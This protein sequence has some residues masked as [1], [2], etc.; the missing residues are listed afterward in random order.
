MTSSRPP[1]MARKTCR[2]LTRDHHIINFFL[3]S[4]RY[5][6]SRHVNSLV[7]HVQSLIL[8]L[9]VPYATPRCFLYMSMIL[10]RVLALSATT[11]KALLL[12]FLQHILLL[13]DVVPCVICP[14]RGFSLLNSVSLGSR[15]FSLCS[16]HILPTLRSPKEMKL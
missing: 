14:L 10:A 4:E 8:L 12:A 1:A 9:Y 2:S 11:Y 6:Y 15:L 16:F 3:V 13:T 5:V 7:A